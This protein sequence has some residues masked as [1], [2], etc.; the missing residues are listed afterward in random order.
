M[1]Q[2]FKIAFGLTVVLSTGCA[3]SQGFDRSAMTE[4]LHIA[5]SSDGGNRD[6]S[7]QNSALFP[8]VRL[9]VFFSDH[10][11]PNHQSLRKVEWLS[12]DREQ[13]LQG[14][15]SLRDQELVTDIFVLMDSTVQAGNIDGIRQAG[16]RYGADAVLVVDAAGAIDRY[17]NYYA[18]LYPTLIGAY[19]APGTESAAF[20]IA[21][22]SLWAVHSDW[23]APTQ[24]AEGVSTIVGSAVFVE[25][26]AALQEAKKQAIQA[27]STNIVEQLRIWMHES[28][29]LS[30]LR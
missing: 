20:V 9:A 29:T 6:P 21:T 30:Q 22:G 2:P 24:T 11:F 8:P 25:D 17:N 3:G 14:L 18:W 5:S 4:V 10:E 13:L 26:S 16:A 15:A 19:L 23:Q 12:A 7:T 28:P 1:R 27:L